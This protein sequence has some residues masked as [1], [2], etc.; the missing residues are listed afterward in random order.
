MFLLR[1]KTSQNIMTLSQTQ[2]LTHVHQYRAAAQHT[3]NTDTILWILFLFL[4]KQN[5]FLPTFCLQPAATHKYAI[6]ITQIVH[7]NWLQYQCNRLHLH[8]SYVNLSYRLHH[9]LLCVKASSADLTTGWLTRVCRI[10]FSD[11]IWFIWY[12]Y[13]YICSRETGFHWGG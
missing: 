5:T 4:A 10:A 13:I 7:F 3:D 11:F 1:S 6:H 8:I 12:C 2:C 9:F